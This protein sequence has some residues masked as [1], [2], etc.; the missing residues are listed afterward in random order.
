MIWNYRII[1][2]NGCF[3][4]HEAYYND[5]GEITAVTEEPIAVGGETLDELRKDMAYYA[6]ALNKPVL[7]MDEIVFAEDDK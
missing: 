5:A 3:S 1:E 4:I 2:N 6:N 7:K